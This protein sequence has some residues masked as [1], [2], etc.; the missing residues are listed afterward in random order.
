MISSKEWNTELSILEFVKELVDFG[1]E[2]LTK[3]GGPKP[4]SLTIV[5]NSFPNQ[6]YQLGLRLGFLVEYPCVPS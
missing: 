2:S 1:W 4:S 5:K 6:L 3:A